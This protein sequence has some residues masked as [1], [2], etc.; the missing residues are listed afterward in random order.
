MTGKNHFSFDESSLTEDGEKVIRKISEEIDKNSKRGILTIEGHTDSI[1]TTEYNQKLSE[2]RAESVEKE[3]KENLKAEITYDTKGYGE[4]EPVVGN[5]TPE[6]R[7]KNR[8]GDIKF[9]EN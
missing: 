4:S 9:D 5:I 1:G 8:R 6:G 3:F 2:K 7:A